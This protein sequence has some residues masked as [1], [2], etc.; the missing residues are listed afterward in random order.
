MQ[1]LCHCRYA[2]MPQRVAFWIYWQAVILIVKGCPIHLK[3]DGASLKQRVARE[4]D[5]KLPAVGG[6]KGGCPFEWRDT[7][8][9]PWYL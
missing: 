2:F 3:P 9:W 4:A 1:T 7:Q 8:A 5:G 6:G